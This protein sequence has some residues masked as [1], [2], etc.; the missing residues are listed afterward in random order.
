MLQFLFL[1]FLLAFFLMLVMYSHIYV[2]SHLTLSLIL[3]IA[4]VHIFVKHKFIFF[5]N[6]FPCCA[7]CAIYLKI[8][9]GWLDSVLMYLWVQISLI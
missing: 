3:F 6:N 4:S 2:F 1:C 9:G 8:T 7:I 5:K